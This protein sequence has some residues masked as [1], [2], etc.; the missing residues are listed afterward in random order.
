MSSSLIPPYHE[1][2]LYDMETPNRTRPAHLTRSHTALTSKEASNDSKSYDTSSPVSLT[3]P[4]TQT[5]NHQPLS[6]DPSLVAKHGSVPSSP[7]LRA[8]GGRGARRWDDG[9]EAKKAKQ[10]SHL[11]EVSPEKEEQDGERPKKAKQEPG[12]KV[13]LPEQGHQHGGSDP[14]QNGQ[15]AIWNGRVIALDFDDVMAQSMLALCLEHNAQYGTDLT[16]EDLETYLLFQN[17]GWGTP[18]EVARKTAALANVLPKTLPVP[19]FVSALQTLAALGHPLHIVTSRREDERPAVIEWLAQQGITVG[20]GDDDV[21]KMVWFTAT[22]KEA[23]VI[24]PDG[25]QDEEWNE[26]LKE[27]YRTIGGGK[28]GLGKLKV[29]RAINASLFIDDHHGNLEPILSATPPIPCLL[30]GAYKWNSGKSGAN[31][32]AEL[33][34]HQERLEAGMQLTRE[35]I[36]EEKGLWRAKRWGDVLEWVR[37]WDRKEAAKED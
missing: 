27:V 33:M 12:L 16:L 32:P 7:V 6:A 15:E 20:L 8:M 23:N 10:D 19:G 35:E 28:G 2:Q 36:R 5:Q 22:Y 13:V 37:E 11:K 29:L 4:M 1:E 31:S 34:S 14:R 9:M 18:A 25:I 3:S 21:I 26:K 17:R 24:S 30:F